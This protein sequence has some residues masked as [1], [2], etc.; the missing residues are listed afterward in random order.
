VGLKVTIKRGR[1][2]APAVFFLFLLFAAS[3]HATGLRGAIVIGNTEVMSYSVVY[4]LDRNNN[5]SGYS[6]CDING[7]EETKARIRGTYDPKTR[8]LNFEEVAV[9]STRSKVPVSEFCLMKV[10]G[11]FEK[12]NGR[13]MFNGTFT[14]KSRDPGLLCESGS[15]VMM[16]EDDADVLAKRA[17]KA[18]EKLP[19]PAE[20]PLPEPE[21]TR[22][23]VEVEA[24]S[25]TELRIESPVVQLDLVDDRFQDGD[26]ITVLKNNAVILDALEITNR[27]KSFRFDLEKEGKEVTFT[28]LAED[29]G[30]ISLTTVKASIRSGSQVHLL[31]VSLSKGESARIVLKLP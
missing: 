15:I 1:P 5:L 19:P 7:S 3:A 12:K 28:I 24:G 9:I 16:M 11:R 18:L 23:V 20:A 8:S 13:T 2:Y 22:N 10:S 25:L 29:E 6:V 30:A 17:A 21:W 31:M 14:S 27:V 26:R 4:E